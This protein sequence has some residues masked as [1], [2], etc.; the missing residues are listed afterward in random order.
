MSLDNSLCNK[1]IIGKHRVL[2]V[3]PKEG[4]GSVGCAESIN[5]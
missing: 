3:L 5:F 1:K 4:R 2:A